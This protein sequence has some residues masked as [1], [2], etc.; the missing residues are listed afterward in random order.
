M[1]L[2]T[3]P[4]DAMDT[5]HGLID[6]WINPNFGPPTDPRLDVGYL[7]PGLAERWERGTTLEQ[8]VEE[9]DEAG[10]AKGVLCAG[11]GGANDHDWVIDAIRTHPDRFYGSAVVDP[12]KGMEALKEIERLVL[13][14]DFRLIRLL[15]FETQL[16]YD[17]PQC[18]PVYAKCQELGAIVGVNVGVPGPLV[19]ARNQHPLGVDE[20]CAFFPELP[21]VMSHGGEPWVELCV[22]LMLKW[23]QLHYMTSAFAPKRI[24]P[25]ILAYANSRGADKIIWA[26]DYPLLG[27]ERCTSEIAQMPF[28][29]E[30]RR[31][32]FGGGNLARLLA[33]ERPTPRG[34]SERSPSPA[35]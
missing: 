23:P 31:A 35:A 5:R 33:A 30:E 7:F 13:D 14:H 27:L 17:H 34:A 4:E 6:G 12:R 28:K 1:N 22:K 2:E 8:L 15:A 26:S 18:Y 16:P 24:P 9:M 11:Y 25:A 21:I 3:S 19:P 10:V 20:V 29:D 32:K